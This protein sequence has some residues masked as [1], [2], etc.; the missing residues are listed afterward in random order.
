MIRRWEIIARLGRQRRD[1]LMFTVHSA[2]SKCAYVCQSLRNRCSIC[3]GTRLNEFIKNLQI[4]LRYIESIWHGRRGL[5]LMNIIYS[6]LIVF[7]FANR[8]TGRY[9]SWHYRGGRP[10][11][12]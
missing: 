10:L 8:S 9:N 1:H 7:F 6:L 12:R 11:Y 2:G 3:R 4:I 5:G